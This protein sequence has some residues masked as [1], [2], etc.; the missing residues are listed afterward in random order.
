M[1]KK[2]NPVEAILQE[3]GVFILDGALASELERHG[4]DLNSFLWSARILIENP[5]LIYQVHTDYFKAG[6]DCA[7][8]ASYQTS[9][10]SLA[11]FGYTEAE[12][13]AFNQKSV[14]IAKQAR[15]DFWEQG[16]HTNRPKPLVAG[17]VG[18]YGAFHAYGAEYVGHYGVTD[19]VLAD[20]H[21]KRVEALVEAGAE[22][23]AIETVPSIQEAKVLAALLEEFPET[24]AWLSF[25]MKD[26]EHI[27]EGTPIAECAAVFKDH[28]QIAAIGINCSSTGIVTDVIRILKEHTDKPIIVYPNSGETFDIPTD[29]WYGYDPC[30]AIDA[31]AK[32]WYDAG[33]RLIGGCCR[34]KPA[35]IAAIAQQ[36]RKENVPN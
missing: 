5:N 36:F 2:P 33:A 23:L 22:I 8:T 16:Q 3:H 26:A 6:A 30:K 32:A 35:E 19:E 25:T 10:A 27:S 18:P 20:F 7:I 29:K 21:R 28:P 11:K 13:I 4:G 1:Q 14:E 31:N 34:T 12:A 17:S 9:I 24:Y 15:D